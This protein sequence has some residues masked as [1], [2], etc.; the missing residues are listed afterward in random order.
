[1][2]PHY[3]GCVVDV[4]ALPRTA[5]PATVISAHVGKWLWAAHHRS[6][7]RKRCRDGG[8]RRAHRVFQSWLG[9][10][11]PPPVRGLARVLQL[12]RSLY[13]IA[14]YCSLRK[15]SPRHHCATR[16]RAQQR[17]RSH[18]SNLHPAAGPRAGL[19]GPC[20]RR[21]ASSNHPSSRA[22]CRRPCPTPRSRAAAAHRYH[23]NKC[24][25][26]TFS[27]P[28]FARATRTPDVAKHIPTT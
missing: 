12:S 2:C 19:C 5:G 7:A 10:L 24:R 27:A 23:T 11:G 26:H 1:M 3:T 15:H 20:R 16:S 25:P 17:T 21:H 28:S 8:E 4:L 6:A 9:Y 18:D 22:K 14:I 13:I